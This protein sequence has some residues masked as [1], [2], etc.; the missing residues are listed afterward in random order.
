MGGQPGKREQPGK[1]EVFQ[2]QLAFSL[3]SV[4]SFRGCGSAENGI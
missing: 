2:A 3:G 1:G 4:I